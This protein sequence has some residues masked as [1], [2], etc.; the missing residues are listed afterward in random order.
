MDNLAKSL[1]TISKTPKHYFM[2]QG[3]DP[4]GEALIAMESPL[5][6]RTERHIERFSAVWKEWAAYIL[7]L[8]QVVVDPMTIEPIFDEPATV[9]PR[10]QSEMRGLN[11]QAG[12]PLV[13]VLK[14][15]GWTDEQLKEMAKDMNAEAA[16]NMKRME[17]AAEIAQ[18]RF[19][20]GDDSEP[21]E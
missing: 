2:G 4:S 12:M 11:V 14:H 18:R 1:A 8:N 16:E 15:E 10:T 19:D 17:E 20:A 9:Q 6:K 5:V 21:D 7:R 13:T 3:G